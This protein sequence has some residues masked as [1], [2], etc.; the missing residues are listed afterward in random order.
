M[1]AK[2]KIED[3]VSPTALCESMELIAFMFCSILRSE[4][5]VPSAL[6]G[7]VVGPKT[8]RTVRERENLGC[9]LRIWRRQEEEVLSALADRVVG[10]K[11]PKA[12]R[13]GK[14]WMSFEDLEEGDG[15]VMDV[16]ARLRQST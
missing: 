7:R 15:E 10:P 13:K 4:E 3:F 1:T 2:R 9:L 12:P 14:P 8:P 5:K 11:A 6:A 16:A